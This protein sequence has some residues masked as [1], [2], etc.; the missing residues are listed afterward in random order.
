VTVPT[1]I[2]TD[3]IPNLFAVAIFV[4]VWVVGG[5]GMYTKREI[6]QSHDD[7]SCLDECLLDSFL[8]FLISVF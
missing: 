7:M 6:W 3:Y 2:L 1:E 5:V 4:M 8:A